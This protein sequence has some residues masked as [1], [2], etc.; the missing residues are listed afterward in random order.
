[1]MDLKH[2]AGSKNTQAGVAQQ[3]SQV[4]RA[5]HAVTDYIRANKLRPGDSLPGENHFATALGVSHA[6]TREA[7]GA[8]AALNYIDVGNGRKPKVAA[9][10]ASV[11]LSSL[12]YAVST[13]QITVAEVWEVRRTI[14]CKTAELAA[15]C[16][17]E[18]EAN[19]ILTLSQEIAQSVGDIDEITR[20]DIAFHEAIA[21]ASH[22]AL[23]VQIVRAFG[24]LMQ[25]AVPRAWHTR[26][27]KTQ[28]AVIVK[29]HRDVARAIVSKDAKAAALA[30]DAHF[31]TSIGAVLRNRDA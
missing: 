1:M 20:H 24:P 3:G 25:V 29:R 10:D 28:R 6:V 26:T 9:L 15:V 13:A 2:T 31:D 19:R 12:E 18:S 8:L 16:R 21:K 5:I 23:F 17:T 14:E 27:T 7:F 4:Q 11:I 22:N 30:M